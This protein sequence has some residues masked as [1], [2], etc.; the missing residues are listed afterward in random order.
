MHH[1]ET[2]HLNVAYIAPTSPIHTSAMLS[3]TV[4]NLKVGQG[5]FRQHN[6]HKNVCK[7]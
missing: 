5:G 4:G 2:L 6:I 3:L 7:N 1:F